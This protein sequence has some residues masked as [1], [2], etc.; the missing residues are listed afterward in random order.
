MVLVELQEVA[1]WCIQS[2]NQNKGVKILDSINFSLSS[3]SFENKLNED[4]LY[5]VCRG[6]TN[7][8]NLIAEKFNI[9][10]KQITH[11]GIGFLNNNELI[12][13]NVSID[14]KINNSSLIIE[15]FEDF[16][17]LSDIFHL[18]I[19]EINSNQSDVVK[20]K[21]TINKY[22][23]KKVGF[24]YSFNLDDNKNLYC[25]EFVAKI[26]NGLNDFQYNPCKKESNKLLK[27]IIK[28]DIFEYF[29]V[30]FFL[31]NPN[32]TKIFEKSFNQK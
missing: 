29:P 20:L 27:S 25:S 3:F 7:K 1:L 13:Y 19:W 16:I 14:K 9:T 12:I 2:M 28:S 31:Q 18:E 26:L 5:L 30:D 4:N 22:I 8:Q 21:S 24:D 6:T 15:T 17:N 11:I 10:N 32:I 23:E